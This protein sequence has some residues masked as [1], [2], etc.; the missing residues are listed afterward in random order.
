MGC[1]TDSFPL[2]TFLDRRYQMRAYMDEED[3]NVGF[4]LRVASPS[5]RKLLPEKFQDEEM[6]FK[7]SCFVWSVDLLLQLN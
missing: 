7:V 1:V 6:I 2:Q 4:I 3:Q 5:E